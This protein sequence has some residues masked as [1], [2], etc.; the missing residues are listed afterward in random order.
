MAEG[1]LGRLLSVALFSPTSKSSGL[2]SESDNNPNTPRGN[3][4]IT[5]TSS[6]G[7]G[8]GDQYLSSLQAKD[9]RFSNSPYGRRTSSSPYHRSEVLSTTAATRIASENV[10]D[11]VD[12]M[13]LTACVDALELRSEDLLPIFEYYCS[14]GS[15][16]N[17]EL[18]KLNNF[19][20][21]VRDSKILSSKASTDTASLQIIFV[22]STRAVTIGAQ[23]SE[24]LEKNSML[25]SEREGSKIYHDTSCLTFT[26]WLESICRIAKYRLE[27]REEARKKK[28]E[29][30]KIDLKG[31]HNSSNEEDEGDEDE[32]EE[33]LGDTFQES[34]S[35]SNE[36]DR[37]LEQK[38]LIN[39][40][41]LVPLADASELLEPGV[42]E[43]IRSD[44]P[45]L[46]VMFAYYSDAQTN[47]E[48]L[49]G[50][51]ELKKFCNDF[52]L[53]PKLVTKLEL[54]RIFRKVSSGR[55]NLGFPDFIE[56]VGRIALTA[57]N[58]PFFETAYVLS[59]LVVWWF[60]GLVVWWFGGLVV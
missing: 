55:F 21:F 43:V 38:I 14:Y 51:P 56:C 40:Q 60:G 54:F 39:A 20:R 24:N 18:L 2:V 36:V 41:R 28:R 26:N 44:L 30:A 50:E 3:N 42:T 31:E 46:E 53:M 6:P 8:G 9:R 1:S 49:L 13:E 32:D 47:E 29:Q 48:A 10:Y 11:N 27:K 5:A 25:K 12:A 17:L 33:Q 34:D 23:K 59:C 52:G 15:A 22:R 4:A 16:Y 37:L 58:K 57:F 35:L 7:G 19:T 45:N